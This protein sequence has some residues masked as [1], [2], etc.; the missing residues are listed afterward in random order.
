MSGAGAPHGFVDDLLRYVSQFAMF[1]LA[2]RSK[3]DE[4]I[5]DTATGTS[6]DEA[7]CLIDDRARRQR[8]L[9][10]NGQRKRAREDM[11]VVHRDCRWFS[12]HFA[13]LIAPTT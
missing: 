3:V 11:R 6:A 1:G 12:E 13:E 7:D 2:H 8:L 4:C 10:L 5:L 9:Q